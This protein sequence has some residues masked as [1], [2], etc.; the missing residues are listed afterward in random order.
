AR[1]MACEA[2]PIEWR[3]LHALAAFTYLRPGELRELRWMDVDLEHGTINVTRAWDSREGRVKP[4]KS[5]NGVRTVPIEPSLLP[6]LRRLHRKANVEAL[7]APLLANTPED[8]VAELTRAHLR[9]AGL[10]R[11]ALFVDTATSVQANFRT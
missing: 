2:V 7:V 9:A 3:E 6:L 4:P 1:L 5:R 8:D 10:T 11:P